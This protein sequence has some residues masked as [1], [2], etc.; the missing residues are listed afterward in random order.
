PETLV[1]TGTDVSVP[2]WYTDRVDHEVELAVIIGV[3]GKAFAEEDAMEHVAF[4]TLANDLTARS[5][6]GKDRKQGFPWF[7]AK[8][9]DGFCPL[10][11]ALVPADYLDGTRVHLTC[12]VNGELRQDAPTSDMVVSIPRALAYLSNHFTLNP[13]DIVLMGTPAGVGP[14]HDGDRIVCHAPSIGTLATTLHRPK[15]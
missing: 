4:Y 3:G 6:Q 11:P 8:N 14:L 12:S 15:N 5:L 1:P 10:G 7:R 2:T 13:G 9:M